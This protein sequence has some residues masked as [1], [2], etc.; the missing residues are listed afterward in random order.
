M[1]YDE[2]M[3]RNKDFDQISRKRISTKWQSNHT[4]TP[5]QM[6][7]NTPISNRMTPGSN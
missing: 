6:A 4:V 1:L 5:C 7:R 2:T 3:V